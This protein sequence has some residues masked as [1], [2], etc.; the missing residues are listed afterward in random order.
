MSILLITWNFPPRRGGIENLMSRLCS[1]I[2]AKRSVF[3]ITSY[4]RI[5]DVEPDY[6]Y[7]P[8]F[9]GL[10]LFFVY[11]LF[12]GYALLRQRGDIQVV[13]GGSALVTPLIIVLAR[14]FGI[15]AA[16]YVHG[17]DLAYPNFLYQFLCVSWI[18]RCDRIISNSRYTASLAESKGVRRE[19]IDV[20]PPGIDSRAIEASLQGKRELGLEGRKIILSVGRLVRRKGI[21][22]FLTKCMPSICA[23]IPEACFLIVGENPV[24]AMIHRDDLE[25]E[26]KKLVVAMQ[27]QD[28]VR[29]MGWLD[30]EALVKVYHAAD[31]FILPALFLRRDVEGFGTVIVEAAAAGK[32]CIATRVGGIPD[33]V[34]DGQTGILT[35]AGDYASLSRA[36]VS[37]LRDDAMRQVMGANAQRRAREE[38]DWGRIAEKYEKVFGLLNC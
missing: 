24:E 2:R 1:E 23:E 20:I 28:R 35:D 14:L 7:R 27:L 5:R 21:P 31:L 3:V 33:A 18:G 12:K 30:G 17:L 8:A 29:L 38:F 36:V 32:P 11:A 34:Q 6:V 4:V 26:I 15:K 22:E 16:V 19:A 13:L 10:I 37:L 25:G 9:P